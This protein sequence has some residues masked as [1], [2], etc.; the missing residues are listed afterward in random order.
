M[1]LLETLQVQATSCPS[2]SAL[3]LQPAHVQPAPGSQ[4][5]WHPGHL[6]PGSWLP[7]T[8]LL[9]QVFLRYHHPIAVAV[10]LGDKVIHHCGNAWN[11]GQ[12]NSSVI[13][14]RQHELG[15]FACHIKFPRGFIVL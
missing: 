7:A 6:E 8:W 1:W 4:T 9:L 13:R 15:I 2:C 3:T 10:A 14:S 12:F 11:D 5:T